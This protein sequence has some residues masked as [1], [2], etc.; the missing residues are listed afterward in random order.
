[1]TYNVFSWML[2]PTQSLAQSH[3]ADALPVTQPTMSKHW[4]KLKGTDTN[5]GNSLTD[6]LCYWSTAR[7]LREVVFLPLNQ[8]SNP[9]EL[10][11]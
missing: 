9:S 11:L 4:S 3:R 1:M 10:I 7:L 8:L 5:K 6:P 2:N